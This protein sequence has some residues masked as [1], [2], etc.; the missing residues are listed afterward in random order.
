M[1]SWQNV[2]GFQVRSSGCSLERPLILGNSSGKPASRSH[3]R[4]LQWSGLW[5]SLSDTVAAALQARLGPHHLVAPCCFQ[6][7]PSPRDCPAIRHLQCWPSTTDTPAFLGLSAAA[8]Q[9]GPHLL[10]KDHCVLRAGGQP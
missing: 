7:A 5:G 3:D 2:L 9:S 10:Q 1:P 4:Y 8:Q 6:Q